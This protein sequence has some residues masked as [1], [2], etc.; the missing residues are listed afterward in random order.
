MAPAPRNQ[1][2]IYLDDT[3]N[4]F[5]ENSFNAKMLS[6]IS[7]IRPTLMIIFAILLVTFITVHKIEGYEP[8]CPPN[9]D[10]GVYIHC[11]PGFELTSQ[12]ECVISEETKN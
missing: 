10:C 5:Y 8:F 9:A 11:H 7:A 2:R 1:Y 12:N 4:I 3:E 6:I